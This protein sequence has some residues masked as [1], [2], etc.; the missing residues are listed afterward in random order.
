MS[1]D[2]I[3]KEYNNTE[4]SPGCLKVLGID[5]ADVKKIG[6]SEERV[7]A[8]IPVAREY[9]AFWREYPDLF[10]D[11][12]VTMGNPMDFKFYFYQRVFLRIAMRHQYVYAVFPRAYSKSFLSM[13]V[14]MI[15]C[16]LYPG[17]K[18]FVTSGG[19]EQA[20]GIMEEKV[21]EICNL[22]PAFKREINRTR[23]VTLEGKDYA[24]Y[25]FKNG[26]YFDNIAARESSRGKRRHAGVMEECVGIDGEILSAVIIPT[27]NVSRQCADGTK[28]DEKEQLNKSQLYI[29]TAGYKNTF[30]YDKLIQILVW[31]IINPKKAMVI[32]G[33]YRIPVLVKLLDKNFVKDLKMDGTFNESS[34]AR[35]YESK[36]TG[37]VEDAF[38]STEVFDRNRILL[39]PEKESS[40]RRSKNGFYILS[41]DVGRKG[42]ASVVCVFKV[43]PQPQ[44]ASIKSLV[45]IYTFEDEHFEDQA[46][47]I[48]RL[49]Y[50][51]GA[52]RLIID[53]NG[54]GI[55]LLDFLV[56]PQIAPDTGEIMPD[57][58]VY[59]DD[60][61]YYKKF[62]TPDC[63]QD[64]LYVI[65]AN[66]PINT[67]A[68]ANAQTQLS[69]GKVKFLIDERVAKNKLLGT[70]VGAAMTPEQ[71][72]EY[73]MPFTLTSILRE[74]MMNLREETEGLNIILKQA[75]N[76]IRKDK[77]SAFEYGLY[78]I[79]NE[80]DNKKRKKFNAKNFFFMN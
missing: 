66:A 35:E 73:L 3:L 38:F 44:G 36:W 32:G 46:I 67:E 60:D 48:K 61:G 18:L 71:R 20:A 14:Q 16:I 75:N 27:M 74:E 53:G 58:G 22:I 39:Q 43:T 17:C 57:F 23:G 51:F 19:K 79:K 25:V 41:M 54:L 52:K 77:F 24:K 80:E 55:G 45:N 78:Y 76:G 56:K 28:Q 4:L 1:V 15:R 31:Q 40:D 5:S 11:Y 10:V 13:M 63:E 49:Y 26:S 12:L 8:I 33:T 65:K 7:N 47:K 62:R 70:K 30:S 37:T 64:A 9:I 72:A 29:T 6:L 68:H 34:F 59:N 42:C 69:S 21:Q 2:S 50:K